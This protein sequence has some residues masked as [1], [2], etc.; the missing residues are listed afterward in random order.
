MSEGQAS[1]SIAPLSRAWFG[2]CL[3]LPA[4]AIAAA[5]V[6]EGTHGLFV[7]IAIA[8]VLLGVAA[9]LT[10]T[11]AR[12]RTRF[13]VLMSASFGLSGGLLVYLVKHMVDGSPVLF[14]DLSNQALF[15]LAA[16]MF[17]AVGSAV[18]GLRLHPEDPLTTPD[19]HH[20]ALLRAG[21]F[22]IVSAVATAS[23]LTPSLF[24]FLPP[25]MLV[26]GVAV[27]ALVT[28]RD[29]AFERRL[30]RIA[31]GEDDAYAIDTPEGDAPQVPRPM[32]WGTDL[33]GMD[34]H[35]YVVRKKTGG[36][37]RE[38][39]GR[40]EPVM[41]VAMGRTERVPR[42]LVGATAAGCILGSVLV[43]SL[44]A[45]APIIS[46]PSSIQT[47]YGKSTRA[48]LRTRYWFDANAVFP[49]RLV[50]YDVDTN[51]RTTI[52]NT[53]PWKWIAYDRARGVVLAPSEL[54]LALAAANQDPEFLANAAVNLL[55]D[56][57]DRHAAP[58]EAGEKTRIEGRELVFD[59]ST[60]TMPFR[61]FMTSWKKAI[62]RCRLNLDTAAVS[63]CTTTVVEVPSEGSMGRP[64]P[65][66]DSDPHRRK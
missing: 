6:N 39:D 47:L 41:S 57:V 18:L 31:S 16:L 2:P 53:P 21:S 25:M 40:D 38:H 65:P 33:G 5:V 42:A 50:L 29:L 48:R 35:G 55:L 36:S 12:S 26:V 1:L 46:V 7:R 60:D 62:H 15:V 49:A 23:T 66:G 13:I 10:S 4:F 27:C 34:E 30:A 8:G 45:T 20:A 59:Y 9:T 32:R 56:G 58:A 22:A 14:F 61:R 54:F 43:A 17:G 37:Y 11:F 28:L 3:A 52:D 44:V 19:V 51:Y 63:P 24:F 64:A